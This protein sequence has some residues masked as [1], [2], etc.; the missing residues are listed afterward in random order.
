MVLPS[1]T[2]KMAKSS[3]LKNQLYRCKISE[4]AYWI[5][6]YLGLGCEYHGAEIDVIQKVEI[7]L[8]GEVWALCIYLL[9][10]YSVAQPE[11]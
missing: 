1:V 8:W 11:R 5:P 3:Q 9:Y 6:F 7:P 10:D 4:Y 2:R